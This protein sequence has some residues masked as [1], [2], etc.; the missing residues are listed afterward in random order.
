MGI[1]NIFQRQPEKIKGYIG[2]YGITDWWLAAFSEKEIEYIVEIFQP[3]NG[4][5]NCLMKD[6]ITE[7]D[8]TQIS[9]LLNLSSWFKKENDRTIGFRIIKK[10]EEL[11]TKTSNVLDAH[12]LFQTKIE[13][14]YRWRD[15]EALLTEAI[16]ACKKQIEISAETK[17]QFKKENKRE[18]L[19]SHKGFE[20]L[21]ILEEKRNNYQ[22]AID[23]SKKALTEGWYGDW[24]NRI[25][26]C[27]KKL[28]KQKQ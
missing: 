25:E 10:A 13:L 23:I 6:D 20:Q 28:S 27:V 17:I 8:E 21:A 26:R 4:T 24:E 12:Y 9:F 18:P 16:N 15:D 5:G 22:D 3:L 11:L 2:Y 1:F 14:F 7:T 19:P